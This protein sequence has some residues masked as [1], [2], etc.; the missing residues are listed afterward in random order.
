MQL[1]QSDNA[2][3]AE[4]EAL[5]QCLAYRA[6]REA[7]AAE[8]A[9]IARRREEAQQKREQEQMKALEEENNRKRA[10]REEHERKIAEQ[11]AEAERRIA[12]ARLRAAPVA[13]PVDRAASLAGGGAGALAGTGMGMG[14]LGA[15]AAAASAAAGA[16]GAVA[17]SGEGLSLAIERASSESAAEGEPSPEQQTKIDSFIDISG[18]SDRSR[19]F[20]YLSK[21]E[22]NLDRAIP[23]YLDDGNFDSALEKARSIADAR[24]N[25]SGMPSPR[26]ALGTINQQAGSLGASAVASASSN[27]N[28]ALFGSAVS[29]S[30]GSG[31]P[32][33]PAP[34][35]AA[36]R[37]QLSLPDGT[38]T[39]GDFPADE[40]LWNLYFFVQSNTY[41]SNGAFHLARVTPYQ[42]FGEQQLNLTLNEAKITQ[43]SMVRVLLG[44][45]PR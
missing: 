18:V 22:W 12:E 43:N 10:E 3:A 16:G 23:I 7:A 21:L 24:K 42:V 40:T 11:K 25:R 20:E 2:F 14:A 29:L 6:S 35:S 15:G 27:P 28:V 39:S 19:V 34:P 1:L 26:P 32:P 44:A 9:A 17:A 36:V 4:E 31:L 37:V 33:P 41:L 30:S 38:M 8:L 13:I 45:M 5:S